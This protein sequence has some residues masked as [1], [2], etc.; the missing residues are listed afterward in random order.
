MSEQLL[1]EILHGV[2]IGNWMQTEDAAKRRM[3]TFPKR[4]TRPGVQE[5]PEQPG[6]H[7]KRKKYGAGKGMPIT[8][9]DE[10]LTRMRAKQT[11]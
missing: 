9:L 11:A 8:E 1:A 7:D 3:G 4:V 10:F 6:R 2:Q 5:D